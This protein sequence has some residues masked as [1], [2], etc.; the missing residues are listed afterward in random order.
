MFMHN[1]SAMA[2][3]IKDTMEAE[4]RRAQTEIMVDMNIPTYNITPSERLVRDREY[5]RRMEEAIY[6]IK[7]KNKSQ[8]VHSNTNSVH[9]V[10]SSIHTGVGSTHS[11]DGSYHSDVE[12]EIHELEDVVDKEVEQHK[13]K[14]FFIKHFGPV[15]SKKKN[16]YDP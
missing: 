14:A 5:L 10:S 1:M 3:P 9:S 12:V 16:A 8:S 4:L 7:N 6:K 2:F 15:V 11:G 13:F